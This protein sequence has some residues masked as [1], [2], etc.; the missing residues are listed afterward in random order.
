MSRTEFRVWDK[1]NEKF[2]NDVVLGLLGKVYELI[3]P[4][5]VVDYNTE[6]EDFIVLYFTGIIDKNGVGIYEGDV[7]VEIQNHGLN[8]VR[9]GS[10]VRFN[11]KCNCYDMDYQH[12]IDPLYEYVVVGNIYE[13]NYSI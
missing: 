2:R 6:Q 4:E 12:P 7:V 10:G 1:R 9:L 3:S 11:T 5:N 8:P 13:E